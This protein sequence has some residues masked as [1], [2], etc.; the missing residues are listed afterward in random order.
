MLSADWLAD[1]FSG[2]PPADVLRSPA[3]RLEWVGVLGSLRV[4]HA[5]T[6]DDVAA[7]PDGTVIASVGEDG[8][9]RLWEPST[10]RSVGVIDAGGGQI[11][12]AFIGAGRIAVV[13]AV[14][15]LAVFDRASGKK[16]A[17]A[18]H[19]GESE[20]NR[21]SCMAALPGGRLLVGYTESQVSGFHREM[22][23][24][25]ADARLVLWDTDPPRPAVE[26]VAHAKDVIGLSVSA[27]GRLALTV[28]DGGTVRL[29]DLA[30]R[31]AAAEWSAPYGV[32]Y[33]RTFAAL[34]PDGS[35]AWTADTDGRLRKWVPGSREP[36]LSVPLGRPA[37]GVA[38][39][40]GDGPSGLL[41]VAL[42]DPAE[43][44][45]RRTSD[46]SPVRSWAEQQRWIMRLRAEPGGR[47]LL[48]IVGRRGIRR[49]DAETGA[50][51]FAAR[52]ETSGHDGPV[53]R[54]GFASDGRTFFSGGTDGRVIAWDIATRR[55][56]AA[57]ST[58]AA[59]SDLAVFP[60]G[61][62]IV[63]GGEDGFVR[64]WTAS[65]EPAGDLPPEG[66][67]SRQCVAVSPDGS[68]VAAGP[69]G[70]QVDRVRLWTPPDPAGFRQAAGRLTL[71]SGLAFLPDGSGL[72]GSGS[73]YGRK[74]SLRLWSLVRGRRHADLPPEA[75]LG[76]VSV[77]PDGSLLLAD[78][79]HSGTWLVDRATGEVVS[80]AVIAPGKVTT[81][82]SADGRFAVAVSH[83]T[84]TLFVCELPS[85]AVVDSIPLPVGAGRPCI[86][87]P[88]IA[89][90]GSTGAIGLYRL[91]D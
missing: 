49:W 54:V 44:Q 42:A 63:T 16:I 72:V 24:D 4:R 74:H 1:A 70:A 5:D 91:A 2:P 27:D 18:R 29:W 77:S 53:V 32:E 34:A 41:A 64:V 31:K 43:V 3:G 33:G 58:G 83:K 46:G 9:I 90:A 62:R 22:T 40:G 65:G 78:G 57:W 68:T 85:L 89:V 19:R 75:V 15:R 13:D 67:A 87:G 55:S 12:V 25:P 8:A 26:W 79:E 28:D 30:T 17:E 20:G 86:R 73:A 6:V 21:P 60:D 59:V 7:A 35:A 88:L 71:P 76:G 23:G 84:R 51:A 56:R 36:A 39:L 48:A 52:P 14:G 45:I 11:A 61:S 66:R 69:C 37:T 50:D 47:H 10:G 80:H 82:F 81:A 38:F